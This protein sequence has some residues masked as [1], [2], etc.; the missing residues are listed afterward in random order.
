MIWDGDINC[1][2]KWDSQEQIISGG[3]YSAKST[4]AGF[5]NPHTKGREMDKD[6]KTT[7]SQFCSLCGAWRGCLGLEP[8]IE[9]Y[10][11]HLVGIFD[12]AKRVLRDDGTCFVNLGDTYA[13]APTGVTKDWQQKGGDGVYNRLVD[14]HTQGR[15]THKTTWKPKDYGQTPTKSLCLIPFRFAIEMVNHGWILRNTIIWSK[16]NPMPSSAKDR[17]TVDFEYVF[18]FVKKKKY[19]FEPQ[20]EDYQT[21]SNMERPRMGQGQNTQYTQKRKEVYTGQ[22]IKDYASAKA[23][24]PSDSKRRILESMQNNPLGRNKRTTWTIPTEAFPEAHF[25]TFPCALVEPMIKCGCPEFICKKCGKARV[26]V[27]EIIRPP[28]YNPSSKDPRNEG[29]GEMSHHRPLT[30]IFDVALRSKRIDKGYTSCSCNAGYEPGVVLDFFCGSGTVGK[31]AA[32]LRRNYILIEAKK[33]YCRMAEERVA[34][35]ES[36]VPV[37]EQKIGQMPLFERS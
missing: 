34:E 32:Y 30:E 12:E 10:L 36:G 20:Y 3:G 11:K 26:K 14:R 19:W 4:L 7:N 18:F 29:R 25:A 16:P 24:S 23:Q 31:V 13:S 2:H 27:Y 15:T 35:P 33:E 1:E 5:S 6:T 9:L 28:D 8:T 22:D 17:F 37:A 21:E